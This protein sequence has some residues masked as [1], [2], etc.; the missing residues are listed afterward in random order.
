MTFYLPTS[1]V[2]I[3][4]HSGSNIRLIVGEQL[5]AITFVM[6]YLQF[7]FEDKVLTAYN[8]PTLLHGESATKMGELG[9]RDAF[10]GLIAKIVSSV[11][12]DDTEESLMISFADRSR[13]VIS[14]IPE[15]TCPESVNFNG[16]GCPMEVW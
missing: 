10:C 15:S 4:P 7:Q 1:N 6:D 3:A 9:W 5:S 11:D 16:R 12:F 8:S 14:L 2:R 13:L